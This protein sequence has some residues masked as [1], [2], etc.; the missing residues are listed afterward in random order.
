[1]NGQTNNLLTRSTSGLR[2]QPVRS[3]LWI[4]PTQVDKI[5]NAK[6]FWVSSLHPARW[7]LILTDWPGLKHFTLLTEP[8]RSD[9]RQVIGWTVPLVGPVNH[10]GLENLLSPSLYKLSPAP[11]ALTSLE[12]RGLIS[13]QSASVAPAAGI[14]AR[15]NTSRGGDPVNPTAA[16]AGHAA[17][18]AI[19]RHPAP[20]QEAAER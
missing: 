5:L 17:W 12:L 11:G 10:R 18:T 3:E 7:P 6:W 9:R 8:R 14:R 19:Q 15:I 4:I 16:T 13:L 1:M 20:A 2:R